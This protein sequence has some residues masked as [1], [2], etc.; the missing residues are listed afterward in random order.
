MLA[1]NTPRPTTVVTPTDCISYKDAAQ[2]IG[3]TTCVTGAV[4][5]ATQS[6]TT[7]FI[8]FSASR[9]S[10]YAVSFTLTATTLPLTKGQCIVVSGKIETFNDRLQIVVRNA[11]QVTA[12]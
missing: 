7:Y 5:S 10:F 1:L 11:N 6:G 3:Q 4:S 2:Y 8:N 9:T 12:C